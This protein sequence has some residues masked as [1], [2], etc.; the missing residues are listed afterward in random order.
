MLLGDNKANTATLHRLRGLGVRIALDDF[1]TG[2]SSL[3]Y[4]QNFPFSKIKIDR[5]FV[6]GLPGNEESQAIVKM[7]IGLGKALG[8]RVT[9]EGVETEAQLN[10]VRRG[11][12]EAQGYLLSKPIPASEV[13]RTIRWLGA[14]A[15]RERIRA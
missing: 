8:L 5:S 11:C 10:W 9:A 15:G 3:V 12:D 6:S 13:L 14:P 2:Y 7:V 4:L 1:G